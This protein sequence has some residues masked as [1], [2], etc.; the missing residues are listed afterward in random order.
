M[1]SKEAFNQGFIKKAQEYGVKEFQA[2]KLLK[3]AGFG[4]NIKNQI[5]DFV[6]SR[7]GKALQTDGENYINNLSAEPDTPEAS[8]R[9]ASRDNIANWA[10]T[11]L[12]DWLGARAKDYGIGAAG[13]GAIA[14]GGG[15]LAGGLLG[16]GVGHV[17]GYFASGTD[18]E[19]K[20]KQQNWGNGA[21]AVGG[22]GGALLGGAAAGLGGPLAGLWNADR[23]AGPLPSY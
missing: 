10:N 2:T 18:E 20:Q 8:L 22:V 16:K 23:A 14:A 9:E 11:G 6:Q 12:K 1:T 5:N 4:E 21:A 3:K 15:A 7:S 19:K 17:A 13:G